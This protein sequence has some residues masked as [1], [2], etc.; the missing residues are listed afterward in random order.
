MRR[1]LFILAFPAVLLLQSFV[2]SGGTILDLR[3]ISLADL[4]VNNPPIPEFCFD[5][6]A[7]E[8]KESSIED[9]CPEGSS[10]LGT[11]AISVFTGDAGVIHPLLE[12]RFKAAQTAAKKEGIPLRITSGYRSRST[13]AKLFAD[14]VLK[15]G[16]ETEAAK[17]VLPPNNSHHPQGTAIDVNYNFDP[18][19]TKWLEV[20]GYIYGLC[21]AYANEW[22]HF[23]GLTAPGKPC[24]P[25]KANALVDAPEYAN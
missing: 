25:M 8:L 10:S 19:S 3:A 17:W 23:E 21:R 20:N 22:W 5:F 4:V 14:E 15:L 24:P 16:S 11:S 12:L 9:G 6:A 1:A 2:V 13:Q 7:M 18:V